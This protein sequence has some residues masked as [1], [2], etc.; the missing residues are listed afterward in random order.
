MKL[1]DRFAG[2]VEALSAPVRTRLEA[3]AAIDWTALADRAVGMGIE[4]AA[5]MH[6]RLPSPA[7]TLVARLVGEVGVPPEGLAAGTEASGVAGFWLHEIDL[8][9]D[10]EQYRLRHRQSGE[11]LTGVRPEVLAGY[12]VLGMEL[13]EAVHRA[14]DAWRQAGKRAQATPR[15]ERDDLARCAVGMRRGLQVVPD[16]A[17]VHAPTIAVARCLE[18][19]WN[20]QPF[21]VREALARHEFSS[22]ADARAPRATYYATETGYRLQVFDIGEARWLGALAEHA[23]SII[24]AAGIT[25]DAEPDQLQPG[26]NGIA[27]RGAPPAEVPASG[28]PDSRALDGSPDTATGHGSATVPDDGVIEAAAGTSAQEAL[29]PTPDDAGLADA[30]KSELAEL[31]GSPEAANG[32]VLRPERRPA[33]PAEIVPDQVAGTASRPGRNHGEEDEATL[34]FG[35]PAEARS[36]QAETD[37]LIQAAQRVPAAVARRLGEAHGVCTAQLLG[38]LQEPDGRRSLRDALGTEVPGDRVPPWVEELA[39]TLLLDAGAET[40]EGVRTGPARFDP[41]H[42]ADG[43]R[44]VVDV[45]TSAWGTFRPIDVVEQLRLGLSF[46]IDTWSAM[47][48]LGDAGKEA[49]WTLRDAAVKQARIS[50]AERTRLE[51]AQRIGQELRRVQRART[52]ESPAV[53]SALDEAALTASAL[54][55]LQP[56]ERADAGW[57]AEIGLPNPRL[58]S[59]VARTAAAADALHRDIGAIANRLIAAWVTGGDADREPRAG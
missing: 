31:A 12:A 13:A 3:D 54:K 14:C 59:D 47:T 4:N 17:T 34:L 42:V 38:R 16:T 44:R 18:D 11:L 53:V 43:G 1:S 2:A 27:A 52:A 24:P 25:G 7:E 23:L 5:R 45:A 40:R 30:L 8:E 26:R 46:A 56:S 48:L 22:P 32:A 39:A 20:A 21:R 28:S 29:E 19:A 58:P 36:P 50:R 55:S 49:E 57:P 37:L 51:A 10:G 33:A 41:E 9:L 35:A 6:A 15:D